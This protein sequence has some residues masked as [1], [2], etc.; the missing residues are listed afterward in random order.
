M[1]RRTAS[2]LLA[3][4]FSAA[5][6]TA[7]G[8]AGLTAWCDEARTVIVLAPPDAGG[9]P[10]WLTGDWVQQMT[11]GGGL[12]GLG[13][14]GYVT[15]NT[16]TRPDTLQYLRGLAPSLAKDE[17]AATVEGIAR[18]RA[19]K[20]GA[21]GLGVLGT[22]L[23]IDAM[24]GEHAP[25]P[26]VQRQ[27]LADDAARLGLGHVRL[28][29]P[30]RSPLGAFPRA[31]GPVPAPVPAPRTPQLPAPAA[32]SSVGTGS[33]FAPWSRSWAPPAKSFSEMLSGTPAAGQ[34][35][36]PPTT[37]DWYGYSGAPAAPSPGGSSGA[38]PGSSGVS[39]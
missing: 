39:R 1:V 13:F 36:V 20:A 26:D 6:A 23:V 34:P 24:F 33:P 25:T 35:P 21:I 4:A 10:P 18:S 17:I 27:K 16:L 9:T 7:A 31:G 11:S 8:A 12:A 15:S 37:R 5:S 22:Y 28:V 30:E 19:F 32:P 38:T 3:W 29:P 2:A 14:K